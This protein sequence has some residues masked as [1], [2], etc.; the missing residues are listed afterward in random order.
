MK[1]HDLQIKYAAVYAAFAASYELHCHAL[2]MS[3]R[4]H[5]QGARLSWLRLNLTFA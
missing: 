2:R 1:F 3:T 4:K 5:G